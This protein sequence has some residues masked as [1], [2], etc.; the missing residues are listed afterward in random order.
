MTGVVIAVG[1]G[2]QHLAGRFHFGEL[3]GIVQAICSAQRG[4][5]AI[6]QVGAFRTG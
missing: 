3:L 2:L 4:V 5:N 6:E 1:K